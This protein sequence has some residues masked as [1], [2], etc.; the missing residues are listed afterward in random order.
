MRI[1]NCSKYLV[2]TAWVWGDWKNISLGADIAW[3]SPVLALKLY[4]F[5]ATLEIAVGK[6]I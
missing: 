1:I 3:H 2:V 5:V 6:D 4:L